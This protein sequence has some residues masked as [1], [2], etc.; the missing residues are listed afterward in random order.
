[1]IIIKTNTFLFRSKFQKNFFLM[2]KSNL[3]PHLLTK[4]PNILPGIFTFLNWT[5]VYACLTHA[6]SEYI[7]QLYI[8]VYLNPM[9]KIC[10]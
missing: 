3:Q 10:P 5:K 2:K 1:M 9:P 8:S 6:K 4:L 7:H